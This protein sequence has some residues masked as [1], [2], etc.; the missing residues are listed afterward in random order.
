MIETAKE[1]REALKR[2]GYSNRTISVRTRASW[3]ID[4]TSKKDGIQWTEIYKIVR[5]AST[6][7]DPYRT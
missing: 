7:P 5:D 4:V 6:R 3:V 1:I 2:R